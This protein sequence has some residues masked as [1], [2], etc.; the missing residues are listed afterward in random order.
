MAAYLLAWLDLLLRWSHVVIAMAWIGASFHFMWLDYRLN[1]PARDPE[2]A[3]VAGDLWALHGG[4]LYHAQKYATA[5]FPLPEPLYWF[6]WAAYGTWLTGFALL[7][8]S[9]YV[10]SN[11]YLVRHD[12]G[13]LG[14]DGSIAASAGLLIVAW[15]LYEGMCRARLGRWAFAAT[16]AVVVLA[17]TR[18]LTELFAPRGAFIQL[19]AML[20]TVMAGNVFFV[21]IPAQRQMVA[22]L[23]ARQSWDPAVGAEGKRRST[24]NSY[25][26][27]P[28]VI[29]MLSPHYPF[30]WDHQWNWAALCVLMLAGVLVRHYMNLRNASR[31]RPGL[32]IAAATCTAL[33]MVALRPPASSR[34]D[35]DAP[36][37]TFA[38][39]KRI[40]EDR[41]GRCHSGTPTETSALG[42]A[43]VRLDDAAEIRQWAA[44][45]YERAAVTATMP[46]GNVTGMTDAERRAIRDWFAAGAAIY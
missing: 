24:H 43:A 42:A 38:E 33:V 17:V 39:V 4:G 44:R 1:R 36:R 34:D 35:D 6:R 5:P 3:G 32:L 2:N 45:I 20:G 14:A 9:Y 27:L 11:L 30:T 41:C 25:L 12:G 15:L 37:V 19:G 22:T 46:P 40:V 13:L 21:I 28:T 10:N 23:K 18:L 8:V 31:H 29:A 7:T 16:A 26:T